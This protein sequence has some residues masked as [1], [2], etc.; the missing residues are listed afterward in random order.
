MEPPPGDISGTNCR[1]GAFL[2]F[3]TL[4]VFAFQCLNL[5]SWDKLYVTTFFGSAQLC[6]S[7]TYGQPVELHCTEV[8]HDLKM[9]QH[10]TIIIR[11]LELMNTEKNIENDY[12]EEEKSE[13]EI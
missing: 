12:P 9:I 4:N 8:V 13:G 11:N 5:P 1:F 3:D 7:V 2:L 10:R 6:E